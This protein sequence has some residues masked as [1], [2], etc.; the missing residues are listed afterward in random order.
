MY[1]IPIYAINKEIV[2]DK[3]VKK[4]STKLQLKQMTG[5]LTEK[6]L[7]VIR[8]LAWTGSTVQNIEL[9]KMKNKKKNHF[10]WMPF[11]VCP[12]GV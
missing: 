3:Q 7:K 1:K 11:S 4:K 10:K 12:Q 5:K 6:E 9:V 2:V 8:K